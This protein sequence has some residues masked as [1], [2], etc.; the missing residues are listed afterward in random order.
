MRTHGSLGPRR[1]R[2]HKTLQHHQREGACESEVDSWGAFRKE[3]SK[4][5]QSVSS[6][7][8]EEEDEGSDKC[9]GVLKNKQG[10]TPRMNK[11]SI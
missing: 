6:S 11:E 4:D 1:R 10:K 3:V 7:P 5:D 9:K 8:S 2:E